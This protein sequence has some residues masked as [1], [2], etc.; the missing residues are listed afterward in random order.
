M[1]AA[2]ACARHQAEDALATLHDVGPTP[3]EFSILATRTRLCPQRAVGIVMW[4]AVLAG[5]N[6][7]GHQAG[8]AACGRRIDTQGAFGNQAPD[9]NRSIIGGRQQWYQCSLTG[10]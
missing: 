1:K 8:I 9:G 5:L 2:A 10:S 6:G 7:Q 3:T 4:L